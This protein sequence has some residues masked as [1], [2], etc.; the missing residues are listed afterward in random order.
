MITP[1]LSIVIPTLDE[2]DNLPAVLASCHPPGD[3]EIIVVDGGSTDG[4]CELARQSGVTLVSSERGRGR[5][6]NVGASMAK[7]EIL[8]F[9]H[10]DTIL[11]RGYHAQIHSVLALP[12][13][14]AG[15]FQLSINGKLLSL[16]AIEKVVNLRSKILQMPFGDQAFFI[17]RSVFE[18]VGGFREIAIME[19]FDLI[20]A[21]RKRG[22]IGIAE[23]SVLTSGRRWERLGPWIT[24]FMNQIAILAY[25]LG[26]S[27][28]NI[29][30]L[31]FRKGKD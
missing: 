29:A 12:G 15:A 18:Q 1:S 30:K 3:V 2:H 9:L 7:G 19:D 22:Q 25:L 20:R 4:T 16:R 6:M 11:P 28:V 24:T 31:Y 5:Q 10:G 26:I 21:L 27:P 8:L 14:V 17:R 13:I 23:G